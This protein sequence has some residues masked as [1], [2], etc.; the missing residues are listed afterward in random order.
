[1]PRVEGGGL[2]LHGENAGERGP[3]EIERLGAN[4]KVSR[5]AGE[6]AELTEATDVTYTRRRPRNGGGPSA[7][8]HR[9][10]RRA[11]ERERER[12]RAREFS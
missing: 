2:W 5:I 4:R 3:G 9:H 11:R 12:E 10:V 8:F 7:G 1:M 6:G